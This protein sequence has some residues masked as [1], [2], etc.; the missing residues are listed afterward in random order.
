MNVGG[1]E[2]AAYDSS[3]IV[4]AIYLTCLALVIGGVAFALSALRIRTQVLIRHSE[5]MG[6]LEDWDRAIKY[7][8]SGNETEVLTALDILWA[9]S[10]PATYAE[11]QPII[12]LF[13]TH[14]NREIA[15][16]AQ[17]I[18]EKQKSFLGPSVIVD[19]KADAVVNDP[20]TLA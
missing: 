18:S 10:T 4:I 20:K 2:V 8:Y 3:P 17:R 19:S 12:S 9:L 6:K 13:I 16:R 5:D 11:I 15:V 7:A 14:S 1:S